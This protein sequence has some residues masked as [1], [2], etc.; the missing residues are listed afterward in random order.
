MRTS[1]ETLGRALAAAAD[2]ELARVAIAR[3]GDDPAARAALEEAV[4]P[5]AALL[6][7]S[8]AAADF[9]VAHPEETALLSDLTPRYREQLLGELRDDVAGCGASAATRLFRRRALARVAARDLLGA[10]LEEVVA[11]VTAVAEALLEVACEE[12]GG[13]LAVIGMG[14]LG[15]NELNYS[16]DV[17]VVFVHADGDEQ[18]EAARRAS[19]VISLLSEPTTEG[20]AVRVDANL[21]PEGRAGPLS[22]SLSSTREYYV[23]HAATWERQAM[24]KARPVAGDLRVAEQLLSELEPVIY[25]EHLDVRAIDDVREMK[26]RLEDY[27]RARGKEAIE[28]K[29]G[30]GG[31]RDIEFAVQLLQI[32]HGRREPS[33]RSTNTLDALV[34]LA[35]QGYVARGDAEALA[36]SYRFLRRLEHRLQLMREIQTH[37]LPADA[38]SLRRVAKAM[39]LANE[40]Q[41]R[42]E[43]ARNADVVRG[44]HER[45]FYRPL[46]E[47]FAG[48]VVPPARDQVATVELLAGL[49]FA[50]PEAA[51]ERLTR[52]VDPARRVGVV[53][54]AAFPVVA[55][56]LAL[57]PEPDAAL[58]RLERVAESFD[59]DE[60][61]R[62]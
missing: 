12:A 49:G 23:R 57:A 14:K 8:T 56:V 21:R 3:V 43:H 32:V 7:L 51:Y 11:E 58:V 5:A 15:G 16:S 18:Q 17:D 27:I 24:V 45:L 10:S 36:D 59:P 34:A 38:A 22:R 26:V 54:G 29:R 6:G 25:P 2:P 62:L 19:R 47:A 30:R 39:G 4:E 1:P 20:I 40:E 46:L 61:E 55:P 44:L 9:L 33:L 48:P 35:D 41:L 60:A 28:V 50:D 13:G 52:I 42:Q 53:L 31:I 37:E